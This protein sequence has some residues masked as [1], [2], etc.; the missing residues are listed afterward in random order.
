MFGVTPIWYRDMAHLTRNVIPH[1]SH[2]GLS[3]HAIPI[4]HLI[5]IY[6]FDVSR[7][8]QTAFLSNSTNIDDLI[9]TLM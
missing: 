9:I 7:C 5:K 1:Q 2:S 4:S 3:Y 8:D 6:N